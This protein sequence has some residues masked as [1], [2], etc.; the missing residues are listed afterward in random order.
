MSA[1]PEDVILAKLRFY[2]EGGSQE[3][4]DDIAGMI[5][6]SGAELDRSYLNDWASRLQL[7]SELQE[8]I[9]AAEE[10]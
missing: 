2:S 7:E 5:R 9:A 3:H 1:T 4:I 10:P 8:A 6:I